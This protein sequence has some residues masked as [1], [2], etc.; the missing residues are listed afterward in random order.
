MALTAHR[1]LDFCS[2]KG[3]SIGNPA[4]KQAIVVNQDILDHDQKEHRERQ[5][6][7][8]EEVKQILNYCR[9]E[10]LTF[11]EFATLAGY[12][13]GLR[14]GGI[15]NLEWECF[16]K[17]GV[18]VVNTR[19]RDKRLELPIS[20]R[21]AQ[22]ATEIPVTDPKFL[23]PEQREK[24]LD[25]EKRAALSMQFKRICEK[26][27]IEGKSFHSLRHA[28]ATTKFQKAD[29]ETLAKKLAEN[30]TLDQIAALLGHS[31]TKT[32]KGYVH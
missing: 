31:Q 24:L 10:S 16:R 28:A 26:L 22:L 25:V 23:F 19:K 6:F 20:E 4:G 1:P 15:C 11:W 17:Q 27:G 14:L 5:P 3:W 21:L 9:K 13:L 18:I 2:D 29:K 32:T 7:T 8:R 30:L 12:E